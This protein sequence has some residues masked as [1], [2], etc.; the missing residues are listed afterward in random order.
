M[1]NKLQEIIQTLVPFIMLGVVAALCIGLVLMFSSVL[2]WGV[3]IGAILWAGNML[4]TLLFPGKKNN[5][6]G[7][8]CHRT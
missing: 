4:K 5:Q 6:I 3:F 8:P 7:R 2:I 1:N